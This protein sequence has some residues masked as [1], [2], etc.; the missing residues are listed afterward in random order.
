MSNF[1]KN[2]LVTFLADNQKEKYVWV[3]DKV[4]DETAHIP[5]HIDVFCYA[6]DGRFTRIVQPAVNFVKYNPA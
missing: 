1:K 4:Y 2:D 3:V 6:P 5:N